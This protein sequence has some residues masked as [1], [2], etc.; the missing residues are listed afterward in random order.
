MATPFLDLDQVD[1]RLESVYVRQAVV[2]RWIVAGIDYWPVRV[3]MRANEV[4]AIVIN[5]T[6]KIRLRFSNRLPAA[7][8]M[9]FRI[10][11]AAT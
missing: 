8:S 4:T 11:S 6:K 1:M 5:M 3:R 9:R 10:Q 2:R 7:V